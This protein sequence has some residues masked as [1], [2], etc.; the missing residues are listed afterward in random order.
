MANL[1]F[2]DIDGTIID[3]VRGMY[4]V[5]FKTRYAIRQLVENGDYIFIASG[6]NKGL[7]NDDII[8]LE[9]S[10]FVL[11]NGA[12]AQIGDKTVFSRIFTSKTVEKIK[13][14]PSKYHGF[15]ILETVDAMHIDSFEDETLRFF[16][17]SWGLEK[18]GFVENRELNGDYHIAMI[19]F[20]NEEDAYN[21]SHELGEYADVIRHKANITFDVNIK[22][23]NKAV[24]KVIDYLRIP[25]ENTYCFADAAND[26]EMLENVY[27]PIIVANADEILKGRGFEVTDDVLDDGF[28]NYLVSNKLI[29]AL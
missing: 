29:K 19:G 3:G 8:S 14:I 20:M 9:P 26:L 11:C 6:R 16:L 21:A 15:Y 5:S 25:F 2:C 22:G 13:E 24:E 18:R 10:G 17:D 28:Y 7:L 1:I 4:D 12:Y 27:H 23:I